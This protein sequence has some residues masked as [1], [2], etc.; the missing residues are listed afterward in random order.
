LHHAP[1][2]PRGPRA[3]PVRPSAPHPRRTVVAFV[4]A[5]VALTA[6]VV[7]TTAR[8]AAACSCASRPDA[9]L[10]AAAD[11]VFVGV[12]TEIRTPPGVQYS[13]ADPERFVFDV[14]R[15]YKGE[16]RTTQSVVTARDGGSCGLDVTTGTGQIL[17]F[18]R[19]NG[20]GMVTGI[21][22]EL[23]ADLCGGTR[24]HYVGVPTEFGEGAAPLAGSSPIGPARDRGIT[25][26]LT[27]RDG[28][29][30]AVIALVSA[31]GVVVVAA[32]LLV[33]RRLRAP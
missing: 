9:E 29:S 33:T 22:G 12:L 4:L 13:S 14:G 21:A 2:H 19:V 16:V 20:R 23:T 17:V 1:T 26:P 5:I 10:F 30:V 6:I 32:A 31:A 15:V 25:V 27:D 28:T 18:A 8:S 3:R 7:V 11:A 24:G